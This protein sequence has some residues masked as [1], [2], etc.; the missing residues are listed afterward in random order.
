MFLL[1]D[2]TY[3]YPYPIITTPRSRQ[4]SNTKRKRI[5]AVLPCKM[6]DSRLME[7]CSTMNQGYGILVACSHLP[8]SSFLWWSSLSGK[9]DTD[10]FGLFK[11]SMQAK[12]V[13]LLRYSEG[14]WFWDG[15]MLALM[16]MDKAEVS[17]TIGRE[18]WGCE[19]CLHVNFFFTNYGSCDMYKYT[20]RAKYR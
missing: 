3:P 14:Y 4:L 20:W 2:Y 16:C 13:D 5:N 1:T 18:R 6:Q 9:L 7:A 11:Q 19:I 8:C 15:K 12:S 17:K 10:K